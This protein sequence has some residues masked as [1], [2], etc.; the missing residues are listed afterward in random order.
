MLP[1]G[2]V[3]ILTF[4][5]FLISSG[6]V[7]AK[8]ERNWGLAPYLGLFHPSL[9]QLNKKAFHSPYGGTADLVD[10]FGNNNNIT[11]SF[12]FSLDLPRLD[13][14]ALGGLEFR[15][16]FRERQALLIGGGTWEATSS[17]TSGGFFP[18]QG[19]FESVSA[20]RKADVSFND[21]YV[22]WRY[23]TIQAANRSNFYLSFTL[24]ELFDVNYREDFTLL[25][26]SGPPRSFRR[27]LII[28]TS[29]TG[30]LLVEGD[31]G[32]EWFVNDWLSLGVEAG[33]GIGL[34]SVR[35]G[36]GRAT[37]DFGSNDNL[38]LDTPLRESLSRQIQYR[39]ADD[40]QYHNLKLDFSGWKALFKITVYY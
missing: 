32:G 20:R 21:F 38:S 24:H 11:T 22:G 6:W 4:T 10:R 29:A 26:L 39:D 36:N 12:L 14:G 35:L 23:N 27:S 9:Q 13:P 18:I 17:A 33:Y 40:L 19:A 28:E 2:I 3:I 25:F 8:E 30:L 34:K 5:F 7:Q 37:T 31:A 1:N 15:W 16:F